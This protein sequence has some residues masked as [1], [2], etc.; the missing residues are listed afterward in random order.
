MGA[1]TV[2][3]TIKRRIEQEVSPLIIIKIEDLCREGEK[4]Q[5]TNLLKSSLRLDEAK[6]MEV[7]DHLED[8]FEEY[9]NL[10]EY[11][12]DIGKM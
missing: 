2:D 6:A 10:G 3:E 11:L 8:Y 7:V 5:A 1:Y 9:F 12:S 4:V